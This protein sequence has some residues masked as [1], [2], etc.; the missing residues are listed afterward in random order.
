MYTGLKPVKRWSLRGAYASATL[1]TLLALLPVAPA[2]AHLDL[3]PRLVEQGAV[4]EVR[5]ELPQLRPGAPPQGLEVSG[6]GIEVLSAELQETLGSETVWSV[7]LRANAEPG[8]VP[9]LLRAV[10]ADGQSVEVDEQLTVRPA[11]EES[12]FP[13]PAAIVGALLA[14]SFAGVS[15]RL[16]R[17]R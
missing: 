15:L 14:V 1:A 10:Y 6:D 13:W 11:E 9:L 3:T 7:R 8:V 5:V 4:V 12:G 16:A 2:S 17:R